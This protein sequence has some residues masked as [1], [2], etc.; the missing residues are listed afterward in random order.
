M[1]VN[2]VGYGFEWGSFI[3][4]RQR[5][6]VDAVGA[7]AHA[8]RASAWR[9]AR[10]RRASG[11]RSTA[12][13]VG[14]HVRVPL[15]HGVLGA[16]VARGL[17]ARAPS[18]GAEADRAGARSSGS[19]RCWCSR[20]CSSRPSAASTTSNV[21]TF[22]AGTFW[23]DSYGP[24]KVFTWLFHGQIFDYGR[25]PIVTRA[26]RDRSRSCACGGRVAARTARVPLGLMTAEP[27]ALLGPQRRRLRARPPAR[28]LGPPPAP[29]HHRRC[30]SRACCSPASARCGRSGS[31]SVACARFVLAVPA[32]N[33]IAVGVVVRARRLGDVAGARRRQALRRHDNGSYHQGPDR[34]GEH[35]GATRSTRSSTSRR[36]AAA[37]ASTRAC[38]ATG[39]AY[40]KV[41]QVAAARDA[42]AARRRL[43]RLHAAH[44]LARART[45]RPYFNENDPAQ[46]DLFNVKYVLLP[47]GRQPTVPASQRRSSQIQGYTL[48]EVPTSGYLEV[49]DTTE[50]MYANRSEH[51]RDV[52]AAVL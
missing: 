9:G 44:R 46:Y 50:P 39:A 23:V 34:R 19:A 10:W 36:S 37:G 18:A 13:V 15:H 21:N 24:G 43:A 28:R 12:F 48:W 14:P 41:D 22:Q 4:A 8:D 7:L 38:R 35:H 2:V 52:I 1:L 26:R 5:H 32:P 51:G 47:P 27:A 11:T 29:L 45:S 33:L 17:R 6:V 40:T 25:H 42:A 30:T 31:P 49:V 3:V 16:A 20:S